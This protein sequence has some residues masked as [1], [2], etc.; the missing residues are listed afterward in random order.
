VWAIEDCRHVS[1][2]L[3]RTLVAAGERVVRVTPSL[4]GA[5]RK[6][7]RV[8]GKSDPID[9]TSVALAAIRVGL[10]TLPAAHLDERAMEIRVLTDYRD[11]L[12][13]E[14]TRMINRLRWH[15]VRIARDLEAELAPASVKHPRNLAKLSR[16]LNRL[17]HTPQLRVAKA[18]VARIGQNPRGTRPTQRTDRARPGPLPGLVGPVWLRDGDRRDHHRPH[19]RSPA[20]SHRRLLCPPRRDR[21]DPGQLR[22]HQALSPA[23]RR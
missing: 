9:A 17:A 23:P 2:R 19:R 18:L 5:S 22:Q 21:A 3:E 7:S 16:Q 1:S 12:I 6:S 15:L 13:G 8:P 20:L 14:R 11:Q 4:T 10:D